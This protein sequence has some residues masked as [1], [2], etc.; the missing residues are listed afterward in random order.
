MCFGLLLSGV[1]VSANATSYVCTAVCDFH[2]TNRFYPMMDRG[3]DPE[4]VPRFVKQVDVTLDLGGR[5]I[6]EL[7]EYT[8]GAQS[9]GEDLDTAY[10]ALHLSCL[11]A[12][13]AHNRDNLLM[14][15]DTPY[16][17]KLVAVNG[18]GGMVLSK[19][20]NDVCV[21]EP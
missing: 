4:M 15:T 16:K 3:D 6:R 10:H 7:F 1:A 5:V 20:A 14:K 9:A 17:P 12:F 21:K 11:D 13:A 8:V 18:D 2:T 19:S